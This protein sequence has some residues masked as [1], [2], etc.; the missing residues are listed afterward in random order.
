MG[1]PQNDP[2]TLGFQEKPGFLNRI[3]LHN[4]LVVSNFTIHLIREGISKIIITASSILN[5]VRKAPIACFEEKPSL[6]LPWIKYSGWLGN[7][8]AADMNYKTNIPDTALQSLCPRFP[9]GLQLSAD[10]WQN[11]AV[12]ANRDSHPKSHIR[13]LYDVS[14][15]L[16]Y[17][18]S[19][20]PLSRLLI[21]SLICPCTVYYF[22]LH[23]AWS[24]P[25]DME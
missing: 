12:H 25:T 17:F 9:I 6:L 8:D 5:L 3:I 1:F 7:R 15:P 18:I 23:S 2:E 4:T 13:A 10:I 22:F 11:N 14:H 19:T 24:A 21:T 16:V 20:F